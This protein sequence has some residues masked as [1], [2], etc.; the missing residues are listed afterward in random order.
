M[1]LGKNWLREIFS[2]F[3]KKDPQELCK[4]DVKKM[5]INLPV[6]HLD[7]YGGPKKK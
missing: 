1:A 4:Y 5:L 2:E 6:L 7:M 3:Q